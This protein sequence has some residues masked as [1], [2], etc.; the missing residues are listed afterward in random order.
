VG[1]VGPD[2]AGD[3][4]DERDDGADLVVAVVNADHEM[5]RVRRAGYVEDPRDD[6]QDPDNG[7][8]DHQRPAA[9]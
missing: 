3:A 2:Q 1:D 7:Q 6:G 9:R 8:D 4:D 5:D